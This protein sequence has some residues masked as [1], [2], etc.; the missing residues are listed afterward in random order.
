MDPIAAWS[1]PRACC[2]EKWT[3]KA[4]PA[5]SLCHFQVQCTWSLLGRFGSLTATFLSRCP[6]P[7]HRQLPEVS[8]A[9][10]ASLL[11]LHIAFLE[12][13]AR[14]FTEIWVQDSETLPTTLAFSMFEKPTAMGDA[15]YAATSRNSWA[16]L[17]KSFSNLW[18]AGW[19]LWNES[20][21]TNSLDGSLEEKTLG[22]LLK[23]KN[24]KW[25]YIYPFIHFSLWMVGSD[26]FLRCLQVIFL[27]V[28]MQYTWFSMLI[29]SS[30]MRS[31]VTFKCFL[32]GQSA[33]FS[34]HFA[35]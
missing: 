31:L 10:L 32:S 14:L 24:F 25:G 5:P 20:W 11:Q 6:M 35:L 2:G 30:I 9:L 15:N 34:N 4:W 12:H 16:C 1:A 17:Q 27:I 26:Q 23:A 29:F 19:A 18:V 22:F 21:D 13:T 33:N 28:L 7:W 3:S 8:T